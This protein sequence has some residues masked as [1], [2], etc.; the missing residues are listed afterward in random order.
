MKRLVRKFVA[1]IVRLTA[2]YACK[3]YGDVAE[4]SHGPCQRCVGQEVKGPQAETVNPRAQRR[5]G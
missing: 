3:T 1:S 2:K 5:K 4:L